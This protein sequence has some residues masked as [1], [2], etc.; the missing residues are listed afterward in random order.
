MATFTT[1][2]SWSPGD[3][4]TAAKLN[5]MISGMTVSDLN[6]SEVSATTR[7]VTTGTSAPSTPSE[8]ELWWDTTNDILHVYTGTKWQS[9]SRQFSVVLTCQTNANAGDVVILDTGNASSVDTTTTATSTGV[10]GVLAEAVTGAPASGCVIVSGLAT[11]NVTG[12]TA[13]GD[14]LFTSTTAGQADPSATYAEGAFAR[15]LTADSGGAVTAILFGPITPK[16]INASATTET[17]AT[18]TNT[19]A[20]VADGTWYDF[21][22]AANGATISTDGSSAI[23]VDFTTTV[24]NQLAIFRL[25]NFMF[26][27]TGVGGAPSTDLIFDGFRVLLDGTAIATYDWTINSEY[28]AVA[29]PSSTSTVD[30]ANL[31]PISFS[32]TSS[33]VNSINVP[34]LEVTTIVPT[35]GAHAI[36]LQWKSGRAVTSDF[37]GNNN[38]QTASLSVV[39]ASAG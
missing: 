38:S 16:V 25:S 34:Y 21:P 37:S 11:V 2:N 29:K 15:A 7:V 9:I 27:T 31:G 20:T 5:L 12:T 17:Y 30:F 18:F 39:L 33:G 10:V 6:R 23:D 22:D 13:I 36:R 35:A 3:E 26:D 1:G 24:D 28:E 4:V 14:Y 32:Y 19:G 8:G